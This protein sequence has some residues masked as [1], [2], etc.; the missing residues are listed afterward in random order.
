MPWSPPCGV[1]PGHAL[2][3]CVTPAP[4]PSTWTGVG[5]AWSV[6]GRSL[7]LAITSAPGGDEL[8]SELSLG[9][10]GAVLA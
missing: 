10:G 9:I 1:G 3:A 6:E 5:A 7:F 4:A 2:G 8:P